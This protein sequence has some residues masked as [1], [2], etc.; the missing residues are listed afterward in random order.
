VLGAFFGAAVVTGTSLL[1][2]AQF[3]VLMLLAIV[4]VVKLREGR[5]PVA[6][7]AL[8][9]FAGGLATLTRLNGFLIV[10]VLIAAAWVGRPRLS[11]RAALP[12]VVLLAVAV[13]T[14]AP[15]TIRNA[16]AVGA[17]VPV[18]YEAGGTLAGTYNYESRTDPDS[19]GSWR[20]PTSAA[21]YREI[22]RDARRL[23][24]T[25]LTVQNRLRDAAIQYAIDHPAY[26][27]EVGWHNVLRMAGIAGRDRLLGD[28][29]A[30]GVPD[31][32][33]RWS[34]AMSELVA[35]LA[36]VAVAARAGRG[37]PWFVWATGLLIAASIVF[38]NAEAL[39]FQVPVAPFELLLAGAAVAWAM[40]LR[41]APRVD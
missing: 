39:R 23:K 13:M 38:V 18:S 1:S 5:R 32:A 28:G 34:Y 19:P 21:Q 41:N 4:A 40:R 15:W 17:F 14:I 8:A 31:W 12:S 36:L 9:G 37:A 33:I 29:R 16:N 25:E 35:L 22:Y 27:A 26:V 7:A 11:W 6:W 24:L 2:E 10:L 30:T 20:P 3:V